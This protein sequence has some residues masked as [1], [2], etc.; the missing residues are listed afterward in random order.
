MMGWMEPLVQLYDLCSNNPDYTSEDNPLLPIC[1]I[2]VQSQIEITLDRNGR[3]VRAEAIPKDR[4]TTTIPCTE[5]SGGRTSGLSPHPLADKL[6]YL[7]ADFP[8]HVCV[9]EGQ[10][11]K[12]KLPESGYTDYIEQIDDWCASEHSCK[13]VCSVRDYV[14]SGT[15][16]KDLEEAKIVVLDENGRFKEKKNA[17]DCQLFTIAKI[18]GEQEGAF[19]RWRIEDPDSLEKET[20]NDVEV[21]KSWISYYLSKLEDKDLCYVTGKNT[22]L[23]KN[24][25]SKIRNSNDKAKIISS[26]DKSG[27]VF[28]GR[29]EN[30]DQACGVSYEATQKAHNALRWLISRQGYHE[31]SFCM[32]SWTNTMDHVMNPAE[33]SEEL[34]ETEDEY[35]T[36]VEA[37]RRLNSRIRGFNSK[38]L[39]DNVM[40]LG[41]DSGTP[42]RLS[43]LTY[44]EL[45]GSEYLDRLEA[46]HQSCSWIHRYYSK[47][48]EDGTPKKIVFIGA[49]SPKDIALAAYGRRADS[50][51][52]VST[53]KRIL[54]CI[55]DG[56]K[57]PRDIVDNVVRRASSPQS[58]EEWEWRKALS[59]ACSLYKN[60]KNGGYDMVLE[61]DRNTRDYLY[62]R[63]LAVADALER[64]ALKISNESRQT[65]A[66]RMMQRFSE[67]P[68]ST[69]RTIE[70]SLVPYKAR[71]GSKSVYYDRIVSEI[72]D[73]FDSSSF[74]D[75]HKLSGEFLL[76]YH[77]QI[78]DIYRKKEEK[79]SE[80]KE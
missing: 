67:F 48:E 3:F 34:F 49:P 57:V 12:K 54:P 10:G 53:I 61:N 37:A 45:L 19:V 58:M 24:H 15:L 18:N 78:N 52:I 51:A 42:G 11:G 1:H 13:K 76:G 77:C 21:Q 68:Y 8:D 39:T 55:I 31:D 63:L 75:D 26:N 5:S 80:E 43:I 29:F 35:T 64:S 9:K 27:F 71:L 65:T 70:L 66:M 32:V 50:K 25:P 22:T 2:D 23:A 79:V 41:L 28:R 40:I 4:Q 62:G 46:W 36:G 60:L 14:K 38:I 59:I 16:L 17:P 44:R 33:G 73:K 47:K 72:M 20:W 30:S 74:T 6:Q 69:W 7:V 56:A